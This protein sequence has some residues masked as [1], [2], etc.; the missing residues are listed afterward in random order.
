MRLRPAVI[1]HVLGPFPIR[2][3][4][5]PKHAVIVGLT[6]H[7]V[8]AAISIHVH[9]VHEAQS[10]QIPIRMKGPITGPWIS[11]RFEPTLGS[12]N[13]VAAISVYVPGSDAVSIGPIA[14]NM[15]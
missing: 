5:H 15:F 1:D 8:V 10:L 2:A 9:H 12:K 14:D 3:V 4:L 13:V 6:G 7:N 11:R